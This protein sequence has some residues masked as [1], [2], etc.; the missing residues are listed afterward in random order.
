M[1][2][3]D[4]LSS[5]PTWGTVPLR[6]SAPSRPLRFCL[7]P[8][9]RPDV[10]TQSGPGRNQAG[11]SLRSAPATLV[12]G[13]S[14]GSLQIH[15]EK[16]RFWAFAMQ[17]GPGRSQAGASLRSAPATLVA[18]RSRGPLQIHREKTRFWAF[19]VQ[20]TRRR[21]GPQGNSTVVSGPSGMNSSPSHFRATIRVLP[22]LLAC[23]LLASHGQAAAAEAGRHSQLRLAFITCCRDAAF[24]E[25]VKQGM[26]DA[27][28]QLQ[29]DCDWLG[30]PDVD[31]EA[32][33]SLVRQAVSKG[34]DGIA[35]NIID[36]EAFDGVVQAAIDHGVPVV[37]FNVDDHATPNA[38]LSSVSQ[39]LYDAGCQL[40]ERVADDIPDGSHVLL[41][42]HD[43]GVSAL[44]D[45]QRGQQDT[46]RPK[47]IRWTV[48]TT[49]N[50]PQQ[51]AERIAQVLRQQPDIRVVLGTGQS[52]TEAAGRAIEKHFADQ[53]YWAAGFDLSAE[54]LRLIQLGP[55]RCTVDQQPY[56][57][58]YYPAVQLALYLRYGILPSD[59]DAGATI[60]DRS[61]VDR[62][63]ELT[64]RN[65]R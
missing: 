13:R 39:R 32:Q 52:D 48:I 62:V 30:T 35:L 51:G 21:G 57:Q 22:L 54:T 36:A 18:G 44:E 19:A 47:R 11:A 25:P 2:D 49:G 40:A 14:R 61:N 17:S 34:Y 16:T 64:K 29:L 4:F 56:I 5:D 65:Y 55:I 50:D 33:V 42:L 38:R 20:R 59:I 58:G 15:R 41:T 43:Q 27:A 23:Y 12:A 31:L 53:G 60:I 37:A 7:P 6:P 9:Q 46:L 24:F 26:R 10:K 63:I 1:Q 45:R 8:D 28:S 3:L